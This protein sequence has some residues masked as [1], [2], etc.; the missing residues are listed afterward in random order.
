M[1]F[2]IGKE[3]T[4]HTSQIVNVVMNQAIMGPGHKGSV[5]L[6]DGTLAWLNSNSKLIYP[7]QFEEGVRKVKLIGEG[8]FEVTPNVKAPLCRDFRYVG[9]SIGYSF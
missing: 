5:T 7:D 4:P 1:A 8:Y 6:P 3:S 2:F 9:Q